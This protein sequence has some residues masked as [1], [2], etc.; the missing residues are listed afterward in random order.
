M[1]PPLP[2]LPTTVIGSYSMPEWLERAKNE[3]LSRRLSR[4]DL[5]EMHDAVRKAAIKDQESAGI[6][7]V[8]DGEAQRD[9]MI[10][11]FTERMPG[12]QVDLGS[13]RF[14]YDFYES[15]VRSKLATGTLG[16]AEEARFLA[17]FSEL[18]SKISISGPHTLVKRIQNKHYA[19]EEAFALDLG[20]VLNLEL[21]ELVKAG[22]TRLQ[23]DEPYYSGFPEDLPWALK[24]INAM[25][26]GVNAHV[27][28]HICYG[29]RYGKP[30]FEGSYEFLFPT[31][32]EAR[33]QAISMEFARR[34]EDDIK[35]FKTV[36]FQVGIGVI[37]VKTNEVETAAFVADRIRRALEVIPAE[38]LIITPDC[39]LVRLPREVAFAKLSAMV[40]GTR[41]VRKEL[42]K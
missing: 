26:D 34:G 42:G 38:R 18:G 9:N 6:D 40:E 33:V 12:V 11:Y 1:T 22:A 39:G 21:K 28:L 2:I 27:T 37:D 25:V 5:D 17:R 15:V 29:N 7:I 8:S 20:H 36:P 19:T 13:K 24:A 32:M 4:R 16:L 14:Y 31:I 10:D 23:I 30:S 3:Y 41:I 35:L